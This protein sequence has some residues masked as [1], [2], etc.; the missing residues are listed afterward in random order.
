M[1]HDNDLKHRTHTVTKWL[2]EKGVERSSNSNL[3]EHI[4]NKIEVKE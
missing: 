2:D 4:W 1:Q 3:I